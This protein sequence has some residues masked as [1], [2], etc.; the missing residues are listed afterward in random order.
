MKLKNIL[1]NS[2]AIFDYLD[3]QGRSLLVRD[4]QSRTG[5]M[6]LRNRHMYRP[7]GQKPF[8]PDTSAERL[9][10]CRTNWSHNSRVLG[11]YK[12]L[13]DSI[14]ASEEIAGTFTLIALIIKS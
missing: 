5:K 8:L 2:F 7:Q 13:W 1:L 11:A 3:R 12:W 14:D 10:I 4:R 9:F 6:T